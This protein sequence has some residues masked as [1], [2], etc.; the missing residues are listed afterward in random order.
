MNKLIIISFLM[1][2][3]VAGGQNF[4]NVKVTYEKIGD[5]LYDFLC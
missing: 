1:I 3:L 5:G 4:K 2:S